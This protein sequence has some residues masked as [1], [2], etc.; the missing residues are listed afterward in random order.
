MH[1]KTYKEK[2]FWRFQ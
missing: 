2:R 1:K